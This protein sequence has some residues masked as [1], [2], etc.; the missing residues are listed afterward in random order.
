VLEEEE[1][2]RRGKREEEREE[3]IITFPIQFLL[4]HLQG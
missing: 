2:A 4:I 3:K 1:V